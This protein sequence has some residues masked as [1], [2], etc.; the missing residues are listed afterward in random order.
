MSFSKSIDMSSFRKTLQTGLFLVALSVLIVGCSSSSYD[1]SATP[2]MT[3]PF[4]EANRA[5]F[6]FNIF[7]DDIV[8]DPLIDTYQY[9]VPGPARQGVTNALSNLQSP[10]HFAN[11]VL[12]GDTEGAGRVLLRAVVNTFVGFGGVL[13]VAE[14]EGYEGEPEDFGQTLA[15]WGLD[16]GPYVIMPFLGPASF[17]DGAG[18]FVD[19]FMDPLRWYLFNI[20]EEHLY[21][22]RTGV[23]I[24]DLRSNLQDTLAE[25]EASSIDYY[26]S[27]R[28]SY[29]QA[30][31]A[32]VN[33]SAATV[34]EQQPFPEFPE[35]DD[36]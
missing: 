24:L 18:Y 33:D 12:Q 7:F 27:V 4:E 23:Q 26:A 16:H 35:Y 6:D 32:V 21:Y 20:D 15:V 14:Y 9:I 17:R 2:G 31:E 1:D 19:S 10:V 28:S 36:F 11:Q 22:T 25:L 30:R 13:D 8:F 3:D 5:I 34:T 29:Y